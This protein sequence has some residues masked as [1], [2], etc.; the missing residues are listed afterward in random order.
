MRPRK[1][2]L[3]AKAFGFKMPLCVGKIV[4]YADVI[5]PETKLVCPACGAEPKWSGGYSCSCG[6]TYKHWSQLKRVLS[7]G[8]E[9]V[10]KKLTEGDDVEADV[11]VMDKSEFAKYCDAALNE[12]GLIVEDA[13][14]ALNLKKLLIALER[15]DKVILVRFNDTYEER[16]AVLTVNLSN[17][18]IL[19]EIIPLNIAEIRETMKVNMDDVSETE[20][21]EAEV[22]IKQL[23]KATEQLLYVN[24]YRT[25]G[26]EKARVSEKVLE[27]EK[28]IAIAKQQ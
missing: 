10:K 19:K 28:I 2:K 6:A 22:F 20:L 21:A 23:P 25:L 4:K 16:I 11:Y 1:I 15:L 17:R 27:L 7:D 3:V 24:D 13:N 12:Y 9:V 14:S 18:V 5:Q 26:I 8:T